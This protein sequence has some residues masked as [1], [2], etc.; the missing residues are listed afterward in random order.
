[1]KNTKDS[2]LIFAGS[3]GFG[4]EICNKFLQE[5]FDVYFTS[6]NNIKIHKIINLLKIKNKNKN[7]II[8]GFICNATNE[9]SIK[10]CLKKFFFIL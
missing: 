3:G 10:N 2:V 4:L 1:M 9:N 5:V 6:Q 7:N 8:K